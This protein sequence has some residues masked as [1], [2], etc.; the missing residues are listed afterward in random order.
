MEGSA[1]NTER[2]DRSKSRTS[3]QKKRIE[4]AHNYLAANVD[5]IMSQ[6]ITYLM[7]DQPEDVSLAMVD[8]LRKLQAGEPLPVE[9]GAA[10]AR[11]AERKDRV[12][13][14]REVS[15][16]LM[17]LMN[18]LIVAR[19]VPVVPFLLEQLEGMLGMEEDGDDAASV[20]LQTSL[21]KMEDGP[22]TCRSSTQLAGAAPPE[23]FALP[24]GTP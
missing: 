23:A 9:A 7:V 3:R 8:Y 19:P 6:L 21:A 5:P 17:K 24:P 2:S 16:L 13:M 4:E 15:P 22:A 10:A 1:K 14:A 12:Y 20:T 18:R 11:Q